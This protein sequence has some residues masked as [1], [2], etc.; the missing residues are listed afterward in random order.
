MIIERSIARLKPEDRLLPHI[1][2]LRELLSRGI[3]VHHG[4]LLPIVK[5]VVE[6]LFARTLV[7]VLF[8]TE[9]FAM[10]LNL[11]TRT[12][13]FSGFRKHDGRAFR[14]L[15]PGEYTQMAGRAGRRGIDLF[16]SVIIVNSN[17]DEAPPAATLK[18]MILGD[19]TK[20]RSQF[21]LTYNMI[22]NLLRVEALKIEEMIKRSFSENATQA[23]L[24]EQEKQVKLSESDLAKIKREPCDICN[25]DLD[26]CHAA[27]M[28]FQSATVDLH[29]GLV[30]SP[31]G[32]RMFSAKRLVVFRRVVLSSIESSIMLTLSSGRYTCSRYSYARGC[33]QRSRSDSRAAFSGCQ[34][35]DTASK[36]SAAL[37]SQ[38]PS[39]L[40]EAAHRGC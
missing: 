12:V 15:L 18:Q 1:R 35:P 39:I 24:P 40:C 19:P 3:A 7:K 29:L 4:G 32:K 9:T 6:I 25:I 22:L 17:S 14:D 36:R 28:A 26:E 10:G 16:G 8:A 37:P 11:P 2:R 38:I 20:L 13:V 5:E 30:A 31:V 33:Q 27:A 34:K 23:L 21:R